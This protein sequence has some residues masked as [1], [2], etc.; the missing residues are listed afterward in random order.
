M[1]TQANMLARRHGEDF[2]L[3]VTEA[4]SAGTGKQSYGGLCRMREN[5]LGHTPKLAGIIR[6]D[7]KAAAAI[8]DQMAIDQHH[9]TAAVKD[10]EGIARR[11]IT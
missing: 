3:V 10:V 11:I 5:F 7:P 9:P 1:S 2:R 4:T 8:R 6:R